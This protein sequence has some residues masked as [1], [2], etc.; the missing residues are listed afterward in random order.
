MADEAS[1]LFKNG[2]RELS[3]SVNDPL[4]N[5]QKMAFLLRQIHPR[6]QAENEIRLMNDIY[7]WVAEI[8]EDAAHARSARHKGVTSDHNSS[9]VSHELL[10][11]YNKLLDRLNDIGEN[12]YNKYGGYGLPIIVSYDLGISI[13]KLAQETGDFEVYGKYLQYIHRHKNFDSASNVYTQW[14]HSKHVEFMQTIEGDAVLSK[15]KKNWASLS[16]EDKLELARYVHNMQSIVF[17]FI[18]DQ[19][20]DADLRNEKFSGLRNYS[21]IRLDSF[22]TLSKLSFENFISIVTHEGVHTLQ[23]YLQTRL[24]EILKIEYEVLNQMGLSGYED[25]KTDEQRQQFQK[26]VQDKITNSGLQTALD[27]HLGFYGDFYAH[28]VKSTLPYLNNVNEI[29]K[30]HPREI[31]AHALETFIGGYLKSSFKERQ[32]LRESLENSSD[33]IRNSTGSPQASSIGL[34]LYERYFSFLH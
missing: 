29:Y 23:A 10:G 1:I 6:V 28:V 17:G 30:F 33:I 34:G 24:E 18:P 16:Q 7:R 19:V 5:N 27:S 4:L 26:T 20:R 14:L 9:F 25:L 2:A 3:S 31:E 8:Q 11:G 32:L 13:F 22:S 15:A 21:L 12:G